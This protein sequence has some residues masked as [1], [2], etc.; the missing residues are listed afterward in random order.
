M[1]VV[2]Y[3]TIDQVIEFHGVALREF[4][5]LDGIRS[6]HQLSAAVLMPQQSAF[7]EDAYPS[8]PE[9]AAAYAFF[10]AEAQAFIDGNKRT[11]AIAM[12]AFLDLN[13][14]ELQLSDDEIAEMFEKLGAGELVQA[15]FFEHI[16][17]SARQIDGS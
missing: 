7:G 9:K 14:Y 3:L 4:G 1:E 11:A 5:G 10:I 17:K 12:E 13:G 2:R 8:V 6:P 15:D 16:S